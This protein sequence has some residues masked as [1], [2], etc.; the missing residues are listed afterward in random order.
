MS[1]L[2][3]VFLAFSCLSLQQLPVDGANTKDYYFVVKET[4][5]SIFCAN[6]TVLTVNGSFPGPQIRATRGQKVRVKVQ[7]DGDYG[8]TI[9][10]HGIKQPRNPWVDGPENITQCPISPKNNFTYEIILSDEIGTL[11][12]HA[13]SDWSR[14]T[15]HGAFIILPHANETDS[16]LLRKK[17][18]EKTLVFASWY[19]SDLKA[20]SDLI[21]LNGTAPGSSDGYTIN[22]FPGDQFNCSGVAEKTYNITVQR[23]KTY[24]LRIVNAAMHEAQ[25]FGIANHTLTVVARDGALVSQFSSDYVLLFPGQTMDVEL[26]AD[27]NQSAYYMAFHYFDDSKVPINENYTTGFVVY[28]DPIVEIVNKTLPTLPDTTNATIAINFT[29]QLRSLYNKTET[30]VPQGNVTRIYLT[31]RVDSLPCNDSSVC[32]S[33]T[34]SAASL[35]RLSF[36]SPSNTS[37][38]QAY[39]GKVSGVYTTDY[40]R[41]PPSNYANTTDTATQGTKVIELEYGE[42]VEIVYQAVDFGPAGSHP[43]HIHG[44]SFYQV[45]IGNGTFDNS[46]DPA[47]YNLNDP[48]ELNTP[49][50]FGSGW[51][52]LRFFA[53]NPGVWFMHCHFESHVSWGMSTTFIV[54][55]G[56]TN[57]TTMMGPPAGG[58]PSCG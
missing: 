4:T 16:P 29:K 30:Q 49:S 58:M 20:I 37:I 41:Y 9:H 34:K 26:K 19:N 57:D 10:W 51:I 54:K 25:Y 45:G 8:V 2:V 18:P 32:T 17:F 40:P 23:G 50:V 35:N 47:T 44:Y 12:W 43:M 42:A 46:T 36:A 28:S 22:G 14:A 52:A 56:P 38:L 7:N 1:F 15:V 53:N 11:W 48:P 31:V 3:L 6:R 27:Q 5:L 33:T 55:N 24:L 21:N 13:H 39:N